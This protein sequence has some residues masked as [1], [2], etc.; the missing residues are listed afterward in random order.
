MDPTHSCL[1]E[2]LVRHRRYRPKSHSFINRMFL[3]YLDLDEVDDVFANAPWWSQRRFSLLRFCRGDYLDGDPE[4]ADESLA[5]AVR[6]IVS[7]QSGLDV[8]GPI[9]MLAQV[10]CYG[11][12]FN[13]ISLFYCFH[14][15]GKTLQAVVA[16]V[17]NTPWRQRH[18]Y[19]IPWQGNDQPGQRRLQH[20][21]CKKALHVSPFM[22]MQ[23]DYQWKLSAPET[24]LSVHLENH[25]VQGRMFDATLILKRKP[26]TALQLSKTL[27]RFPWMTGQT[28]VGIYWQALRLWLKKLPVFPNPSSANPANPVSMPSRRTF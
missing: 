15:D 4:A 28:I 21:Q 26:L 19:V 12:I 13:P 17:T 1:Y 2:G 27:V 25:D 23:M 5:A 22:P 24:N 11:F 18:C 8:R 20:Y 3:F 16:E 14:P 6:R 9:R 10:R 7:Q